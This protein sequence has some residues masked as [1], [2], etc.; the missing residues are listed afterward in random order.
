MT[1]LTQPDWSGPFAT[2]LFGTA[3][4]LGDSRSLMLV[5]APENV[6]GSRPDRTW[7][8]IIMQGR[9]P[10]WARDFAF[11]EELRRNKDLAATTG[12]QVVEGDSLFTAQEKDLG[13]VLRILR[14]VASAPAGGR[15]RRKAA[16]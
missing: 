2:G 16:M 9:A 15:S 7:L 13:C 8:W 12:V 11:E 10:A 3:Y 4:G 14:D 1:D 6:V 5:G